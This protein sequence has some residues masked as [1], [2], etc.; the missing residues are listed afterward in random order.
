M[1]ASLLSPLLSVIKYQVTH[2]Q[3]RPRLERKLTH[4]T[5]YHPLC[6][7]ELHL[8]TPSL[9][10]LR[11][12]TYASSFPTNPLA[13]TTTYTHTFYTSFSHTTTP[14]TT[15]HS[16]N[17]PTQPNTMFPQLASLALTATA[18]LSTSVNAQ[19]TATGTNG[20]TNPAAPT[21]AAVGS[22]VNQT[23]YSRL[24]S[25]NSVSLGRGGGVVGGVDV[26]Y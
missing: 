15:H 11:I 13:T 18:L 20:P 7:E 2:E 26:F 10:L 9:S 8:L 22:V 6:E 3:L 25:L 5:L 12:A 19:V 4:T 16:S 23:S 24:V 17:Q 21:F 1:V 14:P